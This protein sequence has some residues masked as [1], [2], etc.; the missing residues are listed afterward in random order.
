[1]S[2]FYIL[3]CITLLLLS[4][5]TLKI[6]LL[7]LSVIGYVRYINF[8][9]FFNVE[10]YLLISFIFIITINSLLF[11]RY[12]KLKSISEILSISMFKVLEVVLLIYP[13]MYLEIL[14]D[15]YFYLDDL[16]ISSLLFVLFSREVGYHPLRMDK[17]NLRKYILT[18]VISYLT[19][20]FLI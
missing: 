4:K 9:D 12:E 1:M 15:Y 18:A 16:F 6:R 19:V 11:D 14:K 5:Y 8:S 13:M 17:Q 10:E 7:L 2:Y 3:F 20:I